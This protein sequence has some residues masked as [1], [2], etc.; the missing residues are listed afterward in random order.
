VCSSDLLLTDARYLWDGPRNFV[1]LRPATSQAHIF[2]IR[3]PSAPV[4]ASATAPDR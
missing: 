2:A 4:P 1:E 3:R